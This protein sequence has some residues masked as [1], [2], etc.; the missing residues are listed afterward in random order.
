MRSRTNDRGIGRPPTPVLTNDEMAEDLVRY[1]IRGRI[2][3][4]LPPKTGVKSYEV[5]ESDDAYLNDRRLLLN[6]TKSKN[7]TVITNI[8]TD[9]IKDILGTNLKLIQPEVTYDD[10]QA[11]LV[12]LRLL[13]DLFEYHWRFHSPEKNNDVQKTR[14]PEES[15]KLETRNKSD[16]FTF[17]YN[18][19]LS[20]QQKHKRNIKGFFPGY[21]SVKP[22]LHQ[23]PPE[24]IDSKTTMKLLKL[25][26]NLSF[27]SKTLSI[28]KNMAAHTKSTAVTSNINTNS[29]YHQSLD[30]II[31]PEYDIYL[32][33]KNWPRHCLLIDSSIAQI[34]CFL[35][36]SNASDY[37]AYL[38]EHCSSSFYLNAG[39]SQGIF[40]TKGS[41]T[42]NSQTTCNIPQY[43][44]L[45]SYL[46]LNK[47]TFLQ[48][49]ELIKLIST[50]LRK[51]IYHCA[52]LLFA[53]RS[54]NHWIMARP[55]EY[56]KLHEQLEESV[57][58][59]SN[60]EQLKSIL[61][62]IQSLFDEVFSTFQLPSLLSAKSGHSSNQTSNISTLNL[63]HSKARLSG[64]H[65][66]PT[67]RDLSNQESKHLYGHSS[68]N[69]GLTSTMP[70]DLY[71]RIPS[72]THH[73]M[74]SS[75]QSPIGVPSDLNTT[76][77]LKSSHSSSIDN[78][79][80]NP[81][82]MASLSQSQASRLSPRLRKGSPKSTRSSAT[83]YGVSTKEPSRL[84]SNIYAGS[85]G[86]VH[87]KNAFDI[88]TLYDS[89]ENLCHSSVLNFLMS[90]LMFDLDGFEDINHLSFKQIS[91]AEYIKLYLEGTVNKSRVDKNKAVAKNDSLKNS[92]N[93]MNRSALER[94]FEPV[95]DKTPSIK[96]LTSGIKKLTTL[97]SPNGSSK[98]KSIRF[99]K[100]LVKCLADPSLF[101]DRVINDVFRVCCNFLTMSSAV[102]LSRRNLPAVVFSR[103]ILSVLGTGLLIG[104]DW[105]QKSNKIVYESLSKNSLSFM[106]MQL[107][108][109]VAATQFGPDDFLQ[110][111]RLDLVFASSDFEKIY[112]YT[113]GLR[114]FFCMPSC[115]ALH[116]KIAIRTSKQIKK[117]FSR[118]SDIFLEEY[119]FF[120]G[121][122]SDLVSAILDG[123]I[124]DKVGMKKHFNE[125]END[126]TTTSS[127]VGL[128]SSN[129]KPMK[130]TCNMNSNT[131]SRD[132]STWDFSRNVGNPRALHDIEVAAEV[133]ALNIYSNKSTATQKE[134]IQSTTLNEHNSTSSSFYNSE[135][136]LFT[137][138]PRHIGPRSH[139]EYPLCNTEELQESSNYSMRNSEPDGTNIPFIDNIPSANVILK[140]TE[141]TRTSSKPELFISN[142][143]KKSRR[144]YSDN[145]A[146][147]PDRAALLD[148][149]SSQIDLDNTESLKYPTEC[150]I[151]IFSILKKVPSS[152]VVPHDQYSKSSW[153]SNDFKKIIKPI[154]VAI[155]QDNTVLTNTAEK[156][157][158]TLI[159]Y[160]IE[161]CETE[162]P[163]TV[164]SYYAICSYTLTLFSIGL[165]NYRSSN[166]K[167]HLLLGI[168]FKFLSLR[169]HLAQTAKA[170]KMLHVL[171]NTEL[172]T[173]P[174]LL[175]SV[176][177]AI[178]ISL[179]AKSH[180]IQAML[181]DVT[182]EYIKAIKFHE[183]HYPENGK[184]NV[185][186]NLA[187]LEALANENMAV[188]G[189]VAYQRKLRS[190][191]IK[192]VKYPDSILF[193]SMQ[194]LF[195]KWYSL[196]KQPSLM[197]EEISDFKSYSGIIAALS[198]I[199]FTTDD[200]SPEIS[201]FLDYHRLSLLKDLEYFIGKQMDWLNDPD[202]LT[203]ENS[204]E[205]LSSELHPLAFRILVKLIGRKLKNLE[206][207]D[208][209]SS[210]NELHF[211]L[212][213]QVIVV[214]CSIL[215]RDDDENVM[216]LVSV[217]IIQL[218]SKIR[219]IIKIMPQDS[220][221]YYKAVIQM[222]KVFKALEHAEK[223]LGIVNHYHLK[224]QWLRTAT[225][226]L[227]SVVMK[228][229]DYDNLLKPHREMNL[230]RR[231]M[232]I[233]YVDTAVESSSAI[234]FLTRDLPL[235]ILDTTATEDRTKLSYM[236]FGY[237]FNIFLEALSK[238]TDPESFPVSLKHKMNQLNDNLISTLSNMS[239]NNVES[240]LKFTIPMGFS[241]DKNIRVAF[242]KVFTNIVS[243]YNK[244]LVLFEENKLLAIDRLLVYAINHPELTV[245]A[246]NQ[247]P[248]NELDAYSDAIVSAA[249]TR[250]AAH[251]IVSHLV[252]DEIEKSGRPMNILRRNSS[253]T[254][255]LSILSRTK[256]HD[257]LVRTL[258]PVLQTLVDQEDF[259][260]IEKLDVNDPR[261]PSEINKFKRYL[262]ALLD[263]IC[264]SVD[265][266]PG[267][268]LYVCQTIYKSVLKKFPDHVYIAVGSFVFLRFFCP[269][270]VNPEAEGIIEMT[271]LNEKRSFI[272]LAKIIQ[273]LANGS[274]NFVKWPVLI[275]EMNFLEECSL[276]IF[277]FLKSLCHPS[278]VV[279]IPIRLDS[280]PHHFDYSFIHTFLY[281]HGFGIRTILLTDM[282]NLED[283]AFIKEIIYLV[284]D[285]LGKL[286]APK[287]QMAKGIPPFFKENS[288]TYPELYDF[289]SRHDYMVNDEIFEKIKPFVQ[290]SIS[291]DG[292]PTITLTIGKFHS[293][294]IPVDTIVYK[295]MQVYSRLWTSK[296]LMFM[297]C[298]KYTPGG[299][300]VK[301]VIS[302]II[303]LLPDIAY[304][305]C[306]KCY[307]VNA[308]E[309]FMSE[310]SKLRDK[311][312]QNGVNRL[313]I[314]FINSNSDDRE[315]KRMGIT[316]EVFEIVNDI[317]ISLQDTSLYDNDQKR[318]VPISLKIGN[319]F[320]QVLKKS[321]SQQKIVP[322]G[323]TSN[324]AFNQVYDI[325][326]I[327]AVHISSFTKVS[328][329]FTLT[330]NDESFLIFS[331]PKYLEIIKMFHYTQARLENEYLDSK[332]LFYDVSNTQRIVQ[333]EEHRKRVCYYLLMSLFGL[334]DE[335]KA[336]KNYA[337]NLLAVCE[338]AFKLD[339]GSNFP[340]SPEVFVPDDNTS[341]L[342]LL[343][344][345][346][347][348]SAPDLTLYVWSQILN[349]LEKEIL[350]H[351]FVPQTI[352]ALSFWVRNLYEYVYLA[353][354]E[355]G[356][357][358]ISHIFRALINLT[359]KEPDFT[360]VYVQQIF[361]LLTVDGRLTGLL[362]DEIISHAL[363][364]DSESRSWQKIIYLLTALPTIEIATTII[365]K[366]MIK[367]RSFLPSLRLESLTQSWS[368]VTVLVRIS[369]DL[370][371]E[372]PLL[373]QLCLPEVL[374]IV[375]LL[376]DVGPAELR[377]ALHQLLMNICHSMCVNP[378][379]PDAQRDNL[380][381]VSEIFSS[382][383]LKYMF[384][385]YQEK[386]RVS[387]NLSS[388][389]FASKFNI[390]D[391]F[392][393]NILAL[394]EYSSTSEHRQWKTRYRKY[395][396]ES[397]F[398][399][400]SFLSARAMMIIGIISKEYTSESL[401]RN[402]FLETMKVAAEPEF[403][404]EH[405]FLYISHL[406]AYTKIADGLKPSTPI[407]KRLFWFAVFNAT[408]T[409]AT[410]FEGGLLL[411]TT[412][413]K[414]LY[415]AYFD[416]NWSSESLFEILLR[417]KEFACDIF[418]ELGELTGMTWNSDT[419]LP[420]I[421]LFILK[422]LSIPF[423]KTIAMDCLV[424]LFRNGYYEF[425]LHSY[426][427][428]YLSFMLLLF[429]MLNGDQ[430]EEV[431]EEVDF[432][433]KKVGIGINHSV[434]E[435]LLD[436]LVSESQTSNVVLYQCAILFASPMSD[437]QIRFKFQLVV[438]Y[439]LKVNS[440]CVLRFYAIIQ[441]QMRRTS[442]YE[443]RA[444]D[445]P[446]VID[447]VTSLVTGNN[448][449][450]VPHYY[451]L[452]LD[453]LKAKKLD[454]LNSIEPFD[455]G[456]GAYR[457]TI[458]NNPGLIL[459][460]KKLITRLLYNL[461]NSV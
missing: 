167:M 308:N 418:D 405:L 402:L 123:S 373:A 401:C 133:D 52:L 304:T 413:L 204:K 338:T 79:S 77:S 22:C 24:P 345:T 44:E 344:E 309:N 143:L 278:R 302:L 129:L 250:N 291:V 11:I 313:S 51:T 113:E 183:A 197:P 346:L 7:M 241:K 219:A 25:L 398:T 8:I 357:S 434:P 442:L 350:P 216:L 100:L 236:T 334:F 368:E 453:E 310:F 61:S 404:D 1:I 352:C 142:D 306:L 293:K 297:D 145:S 426:E 459:K 456:M 156:F 355:N 60:D 328:T 194:Q 97:P 214:I 231:D 429:L 18:R 423:V 399:T 289:M 31:L 114:L 336:V 342:S 182:K 387:Q 17:E 71:S 441:Q 76:R 107:K 223:G 148:S 425:M 175:G 91:D 266:F 290:E 198:G 151:N 245:S 228:N 164:R 358:S 128:K 202:L 326:Q 35:A 105:D 108:F 408:S 69:Q 299:I 170:T 50:F 178:I 115:K 83:Q 78:N 433:G 369:V 364:R 46:F 225:D 47:Y 118:L 200:R 393:T 317:R 458:L 87:L 147:R 449:D 205:I 206:N 9:T 394:M 339:F 457:S 14:D 74:G 262:R 380:N 363:E 419:L 235:E 377:A 23:L 220:T 157:M 243:N 201:A 38:R 86:I 356:P 217:G 82:S 322:K 251:L 375:S 28:L 116:K 324:F 90:L 132:H 15:E 287:V 215:T 40:S 179:Y 422:G 111:L 374:F 329:E 226:W 267:E 416:E 388:S 332:N 303:N 277:S 370:F 269:V 55:G 13:A 227:K 58:T 135:N 72:A 410:M 166:H 311:E 121:K 59:S 181:R 106:V 249:D 448:Y 392:I 261:A 224:N 45:F 447:I 101:S 263:S 36:A 73:M 396:M 131:P 48:M 430:F 365:Q 315:L 244:K 337:Y 366:L 284:D 280:A 172:F 333:E 341:F 234:V 209:N 155:V 427:K 307:Y 440:D 230:R 256:G 130:S 174:Q 239:N 421:I 316:G 85:S 33:E 407:L 70:S 138:K 173:F 312:A 185:P 270:L 137:P 39:L 252:E 409:D 281:I 6:L 351:E 288:D 460:R 134:D 390:L 301:R 254:R 343:S 259:F 415:M 282:T 246:A 168:I 439:I 232:D 417:E 403:T 20:E 65:Y 144:T 171:K 300:D 126:G 438:R 193:D 54:I 203:R 296:H 141:M 12:L 446:V 400:D 340:K 56:L 385:F 360:T 199:L 397:V 80:N 273:T 378:A 335:D 354:P 150:M 43:L 258:K 41:P 298:S 136:I 29:S 420:L 271:Y 99:L 362:T 444:T 10:Q 180:N 3:P 320:F 221:I 192:F 424:V 451:Q 386:I 435:V 247:C 140:S 325:S 274:E 112:L 154:F 292:V 169:S 255:T 119:T 26:R 406:F 331:S 146:P 213:E 196:S 294:D 381:E 371:F 286:G 64:E 455:Q 242:L 327:S 229:V 276:K 160:V 359:V 443:A 275:H 411:M 92:S 159:E 89:A 49:L 177:R 383:K 436:W 318:F 452:F 5:V 431:L 66:A 84:Q 75:V 305:N 96:Q 163:L 37:F 88:F 349:G 189:A 414:R 253:A 4:I 379:L 257:Y 104:Q 268:L 240:S 42:N 285:I 158:D 353:D 103:R 34:Y 94:T 314:S 19:R 330:F 30:P 149:K 461:S 450:K 62:N 238:C 218:I 395:L 139:K 162:E 191:I 67:T 454:V 437:H 188:S 237:Y 391:S 161:F 372:A 81:V 120:E 445:V 68:P 222:A 184:E 233:L 109:F 265:S 367:I 117:L 207:I 208:W 389:S 323:G 412:C 195:A 319:I 57:Y 102:S 187:F 53:Q 376:I 63:D 212:L 264:V 110:H 152:F 260:D 348:K 2:V 272:T 122:F 382:Q 321:S 347:S 384:G 283:F 127:T 248:A 428:H 210:F 95:K 125:I 190:N 21:G 93:F 211:I 176:G 432:V 165:F 27:N 279:N 295:F 16:K 186:Q 153:V 124:I 98:K 32:S 361:F